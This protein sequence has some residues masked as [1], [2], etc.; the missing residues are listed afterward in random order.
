MI[1]IWHNNRCGKSRDG[2]KYLEEKGVEFEIF[3]YLK[4]DLKAN[5]IKE[6]ISQLGITEIRDMMRTKEVAY[7][8]NNLKDSSLTQDEIIDII[9]N[10]PKLIERPVVIN[11]NK[12]VIARP[13][14]KIEEIL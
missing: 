4:S 7:K 5:D 8:E 11:N 13:V 3:E 1:K 9:I 12:A 6:L 10:N 14:E 2:V